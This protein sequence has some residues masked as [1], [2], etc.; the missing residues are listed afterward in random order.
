MLCA[1]CTHDRRHLRDRDSERYAVRAWESNVEP[2]H[3]DKEA[4]LPI[5]AERQPRVPMRDVDRAVAE[6]PGYCAVA[7]EQGGIGLKREA[8]VFRRTAAPVRN[9]VTVDPHEPAVGEADERR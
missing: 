2:G 6:C 3:G 1:E 5:E 4:P 7:R 9:I 8:H